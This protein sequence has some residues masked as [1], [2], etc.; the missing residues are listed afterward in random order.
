[1]FGDQND[2][3]DKNLT[4]LRDKLSDFRRSTTGKSSKQTPAVVPVAGYSIDFWSVLTNTVVLLVLSC[5]CTI[6]SAG[7]SQSL[8]DIRATVLNFL[9][10]NVDAKAQADVQYTI[11]NLDSRL[12][13]NSCSQ[14]LQAFL[15]PSADLNGKTTVGVRCTANRPWTVYVPVEVTVFHAVLV[16]QKPLLRGHVLER[17][18]LSQEK[19]NVNQTSSGYYNN[20][21]ELVGMVVRRAMQ[22]GEVFSPRLL[23]APKL[24]KRGEFVTVLAETPYLKVRM[25]GKAL[26]DGAKGEVVRVINLKSKKVVEGVVTH[27]GVVRVQM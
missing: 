6:V 5:A 23:Q 10:S 22:T 3:T 1:M 24:V 11:G 19:I 2:I 17:G 13:L 9:M 18:D 21:E 8:D 4:T 16:A 12:K 26:S 14:P 15:P 25:Q 27:S 20:P 7:E